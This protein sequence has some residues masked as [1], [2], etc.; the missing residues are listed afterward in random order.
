MALIVRIAA[1]TL[2]FLIAALIF[3]SGTGSRASSQPKFWAQLYG[4]SQGRDCSAKPVSD[5]KRRR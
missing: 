1:H 4:Q 3:F 2:L 5:M